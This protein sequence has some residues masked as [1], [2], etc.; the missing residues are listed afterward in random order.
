[1]ESNKY[2]PVVILAGGYGTR[3]SSDPERIPK[4]MIKIGEQPILWHIMKIYYYYG[5][6][7]FIICAGFKQEL[8]KNY[9]I[10]YIYN[11]ASSV[12]IHSNKPFRLSHKEIPED[13]NVTIVDTGLNTNTGGRLLQIK[14]YLQTYIKEK[15]NFYIADRFCMA[16]GDS[17]GNINLDK[18][19][20]YH[21]HHE[22]IATLTAVRPSEKYGILDIKDNGIVN[23][24]E[25]KP[26]G[27]DKWVNGGF[28][29]LETPEIFDYIKEDVMFEQEPL[30]KLVNDDQLTAFY[31]HDFW[32]AM[33]TVKE[34]K[35]LEE[36]WKNGDAPWKIW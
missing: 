26:S 13:W 34:H 29:I 23:T 15:N 6:R 35:E 7:E 33:D 16:Y 21:T 1:M 3:M 36:K 12:C 19:V 18:L 2:I 8:I 4:P 20:E 9:F 5:F 30:K 31:H 27:V 22:K 25:E 10:N 24:Y 28:A 17:I 32:H 14:R 11:T